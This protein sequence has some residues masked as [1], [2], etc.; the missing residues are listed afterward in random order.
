MAALTATGPTLPVTWHD[1]DRPRQLLLWGLRTWVH[2]VKKGV[3]PHEHLTAG[4]LPFGLDG[5]IPALETYLMTV[6]EHATCQLDVRCPPCRQVSPDER[7]LLAFV[8]ACHDTRGPDGTRNGNTAAIK[9]FSRLVGPAGMP[10]C[11]KAAFELAIDFFRPVRE[12]PTDT[13]A[14]GT[15]DHGGAIFGP[16]PSACIH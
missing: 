4:L 11:I 8:D 2:G 1:L 5:A 16:S 9:G 14:G 13:L 12:A 15:A 6:A 10:A 7:A 3:C